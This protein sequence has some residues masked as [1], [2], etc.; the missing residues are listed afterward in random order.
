MRI[1]WRAHTRS[2][3]YLASLTLILL[4]SSIWWGVREYQ[5]AERATQ[6]A[7][8]AIQVNLQQ[9]CSSIEQDASI[10]LPAHIAGNPSRIWEA[11][12]EAIARVR[13]KQLHCSV[14][15]N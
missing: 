8:H 7:N 14:N 4:S 10:P 13:A 6:A 3:A 11:Q 12:F 9:R 1:S 5:A 2:I 15:G